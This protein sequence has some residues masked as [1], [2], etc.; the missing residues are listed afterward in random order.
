MNWFEG[1]AYVGGTTLALQMVPQFYH[2]Y[3]T[4]SAADLSNLFLI[5]N[6]FGLICMCSYS[7]HIADYPLSITTSLSLFNTVVVF[8]YKIYLDWKNQISNNSI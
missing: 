3:K 2:L 6:I 4:K 7:I 1:I 8:G 5:S